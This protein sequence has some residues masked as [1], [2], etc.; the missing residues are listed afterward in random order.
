MCCVD[1]CV[2]L[3]CGMKPQSARHRGKK[4]YF[5]HFCLFRLKHSIGKLTW[6][7]KLSTL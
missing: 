1:L 3:L 7:M 2:L 5:V 4:S 6:F